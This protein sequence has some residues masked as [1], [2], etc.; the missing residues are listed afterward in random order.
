MGFITRGSGI[1]VHRSD[2]VNAYD[3][4]THQND[5]IVGVKWLEGA[6]SLFLVNIQVE[7]LPVSWTMQTLSWTADLIAH[8]PAGMQMHWG[9][10]K[11]QKNC[12]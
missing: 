12:E 1:S 8:I 2:C 10:H 11:L 5:R 7:A 9:V 6:S 4:H 3:L